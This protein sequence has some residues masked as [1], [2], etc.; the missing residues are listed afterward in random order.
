MIKVELLAPAGNMMCLKAAIEAGCDAV[1]LAGNLYGA[2][3]FAGNFNNEELVEAINMAHLYGVKV[4]IAANTLIYE[5]EV[6]TFLDYIRFIHKI[7]AD[8]VIVQDLGMMDL[9]R[10]KFPNLEIHASTQMHIHNY[11]GALLA[12]KLGIKRIVIARETPI[13]VIEKIKRELNIEVEVFIHGALCVSY[14]GQCLMSSLIGNRSGNRGTCSQCCRKAYDLYDENSNKLSNDKYLLSTKDL[15]TLENIDKLIEIGVNSLKIEGRMKRPEYVYLVTKIYRKVIDSYYETG[16]LNISKEDIIELEKIFNRSF[17]KG[18]IFGEENDNYVY[19][20]RPNHKGIL[21]GSVL[22]KINNDLKIKL[23]HDINLHDALRIL[24]DK[25]DK[26]IVINKMFIEKK[27]V[28]SAKKGD[29]ITIKYDKFV[30]KNSKVLLTTDYN[31]IR[32]INNSLSNLKR[33]VLIDIYFEAKENEKAFIK[34]SDGVNEVSLYSSFIVEE[35]RN[36][37]ISKENIIKQLTKTGNTVYKVGNTRINIGNIF[38]SIKD[39]NEL[40]RNV[41]EKLNQKRL[42]KK[43]FI[44]NDYY[45]EL[46]N[47]SE[48]KYNA[49]LLNVEDDY[50]KYK[51]KYDLIYTEN[52]ALLK[53][54]NVIYKM[55][56]VINRYSCYDK[57]VLIGELGSIIKYKEFDT[58]FSFN[59]VN[60]Y[61]LAFLHNMGAKCVTLSY[62]LNELQIENI[63]ESYNKRYG[64]HPNTSVIVSSYPEAM[65]CKFDLNKM[66][67]VNKSF[68]VDE[69][70]NKY[71]IESKSDFMRIYNYQKKEYL[72]HEELYKIG[73]NVL[74]VNI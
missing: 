56:R 19:Q 62:E 4:Y 73:V 46:P 36:V 20:K 8:A 52:Q 16:K 69:F 49:V 44:E 1:Y 48:E 55:P 26:G 65:I 63:I 68:L 54:N 27:E 34:A 39:I 31:Q 45:I 13:D 58:D 35:A 74:R 64:K 50:F 17:T 42:Y 10:K 23:T 70:N 66:F 28:L 22:S 24:D 2:R 61:S 59:V 21:V 43:D 14:S 11:E 32:K 57:R 29:I 60:S 6:N 41:L 33:K 9:I 7:G 38:L 12:Q 40:R 25:E 67:G 15:C 5:R 3:S 51:D 37:P 30:E 72:N 18:F 47:F 71:K 53:Y